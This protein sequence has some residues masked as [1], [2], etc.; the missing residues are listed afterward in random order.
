MP[1]GS[2]PSRSAKSACASRE[3]LLPFPRKGGLILVV[4][5]FPPRC[6]TVAA[7]AALGFRRPACSP[8]A[9]V[10]SELTLGAPAGEDW[11]LGCS[12]RTA[13]FT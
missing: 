10:A 7:L 12:L 5:E 11:G 9:V 6:T 2:R 13:F 1:W 3:L 4:F 8:L